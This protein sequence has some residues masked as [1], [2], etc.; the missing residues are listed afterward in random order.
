MPP[1]SEIA[2]PKASDTKKAVKP[3]KGEAEV[4]PI[5]STRRWSNQEISALLDRIGDILSIM[6]E[7]RFKIIAYQ[8]ASDVIEHSSRGIQDIWQGDT[9]NLRAIDGVGEAIADKLDELFR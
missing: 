3:K 8:R 1:K 7:N 4:L 6:G 2:K 9:A 5:T